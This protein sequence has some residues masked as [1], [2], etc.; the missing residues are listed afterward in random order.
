[1]KRDTKTYSPVFLKRILIKGINFSESTEYCIKTID[2][3]VC[4]FKLAY[5]VVR[6]FCSQTDCQWV[7]MCDRVNCEPLINSKQ[8]SFLETTA[9]PL[10]IGSDC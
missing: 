7:P 6:E 2:K 9:L 4:P 5:V 10:L 8:D 3:T 1:M